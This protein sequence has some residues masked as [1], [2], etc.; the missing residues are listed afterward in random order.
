[1]RIMAEERG[2]SVDIAGYEKLMEEARE[3]ARSGGRT[4]NTRLSTL[5][6]DALAQ[7]AQANV[8]PTDDKPKFSHDPIQAKVMA[9]WNGDDLGLAPADVLEDEELAIVLDRTNFYARWGARLETA[10]NYA[11]R[12]V[13]SSMSRRQKSPV[14]MCCT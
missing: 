8:K 10:A 14:D 9:I 5:P 7:L 11:A 4:E 2:M 13:R 12:A 6:P 1:T 3:L